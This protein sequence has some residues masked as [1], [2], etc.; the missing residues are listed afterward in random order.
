MAKE[1]IVYINGQF[2]P[3]SHVRI[4]PFDHGLLYGDGIYETLRVYS[5]VIFKLDQH[6]DRLFMSAK[7]LRLTI[8]LTKEQLKEAVAEVVRR[9]GYRESHIRIVVT[10]GVGAG[11]GLRRTIKTPPTVFIIDVDRESLANI[12]KSS[13]EGRGLRAIIASTRSVPSGCGVES[14]A[15]H[16]NYLN[17]IMVDL[18]AETAGADVAISLD[19]NGLVTECSG[20]NIYVVKGGTI[21]TPPPHVGILA[22]I[23]RQTVVEI[24]VSEGI[25]FVERMLTPYD[26]YTADEVFATSTV[27]GI[28]PIVEVDSRI[29]G[30]GKP[31]PITSRIRR[32]YND[33]LRKEIRDPEAASAGK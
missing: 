13:D 31:G 12:V 16:N 22:G 5:Q 32:R 1:S 10:A 24:A 19:I 6:L 27:A 30:E 28:A 15:K 2:L 9:N 3:E 33:L 29:I 11:M 17:H 21:A 18:E 4:S 14:R 7:A 26:I 8:P 20:A 23:T 25:Q